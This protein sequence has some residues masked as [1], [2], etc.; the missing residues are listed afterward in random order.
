[1]RRTMEQTDLE[2][3]IAFVTRLRPELR[4]H[5]YRICGNWHTADD[6]VQE[7]FIV[8][9]QRWKRISEDGRNAYA[10]TVLAHLWEN[11][12]RSAHGHLESLPGVLPE[13]SLQEED[14]ARL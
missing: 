5:A 14:V 11:E 9:H 1:M 4:Q 7:T 3:F 6:L 2:D 12:C 8:L 10:R 13:L